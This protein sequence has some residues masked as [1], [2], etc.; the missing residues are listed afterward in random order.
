VHFQ[1][2]AP[3]RSPTTPATPASRRT[4]R[5]PSSHVPLENKAA[6]VY[7]FTPLIPPHQ[8]LNRLPS[9]LN[10]QPYPHLFM[11]L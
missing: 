2:A 9:I 6:T 7:E 11:S 4:R 1:S 5:S 10:P 8:T 3:A